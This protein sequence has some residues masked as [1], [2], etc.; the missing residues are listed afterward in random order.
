MVGRT[1]LFYYASRIPILYVPL[2][3]SFLLSVTRFIFAM[4]CSN[5]VF[6]IFC[7]SF[8][9]YTLFLLLPIRLFC[10]LKCCFPFSYSFLLSPLVL[11][12][13]SFIYI[14]Q[15]FIHLYLTDRQVCYKL[16][17]LYGYWWTFLGEL[18]RSRCEL[19]KFSAF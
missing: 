8:L 10:F 19:F 14:L 2:H 3:H 13:S 9:F 16:L 18:F 12:S 11:S 4:L 6:S 5:F 17:N 7:S 15:I 1:I